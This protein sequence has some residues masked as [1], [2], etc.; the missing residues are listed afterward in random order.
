MNIKGL[1]SNLYARS[2]LNKQFSSFDQINKKLTENINKEENTKASA[3]KA[4]L[5]NISALNAESEKDPNYFIKGF[6]KEVNVTYDSAKETI[7][8]AVNACKVLED[9]NSS[10]KDKFF[11]ASNLEG[12]Y[13]NLDRENEIMHIQYVTSTGIA[14]A[15]GYNSPDSLAHFMENDLK[16][17]VNIKAQELGI[18]GMINSSTMFPSWYNDIKAKYDNYIDTKQFSKAEG[19]FI[20]TSDLKYEA[21]STLNSHDFVKGEFKADRGSLKISSNTSDIKLSVTDSKAYTIW[22]RNDNETDN[23]DYSALNELKDKLTKVLDKISKNQ[24]DIN[25]AGIKALGINCIV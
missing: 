24:D 16:S 11:A 4:K 17:A 5:R 6:I 12:L 14:S 2:F 3:D 23:I 25:Q 20:D 21:V 7:E 1:S 13:E 15:N 8:T 18:D 10:M 9:K 19:L 22:T